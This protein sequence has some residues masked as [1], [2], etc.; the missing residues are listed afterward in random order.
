M[1][2]LSKKNLRTESVQFMNKSF[3]LTELDQMIHWK[4]KKKIIDKKSSKPH[5]ILVWQTDRN[6]C[7]VPKVS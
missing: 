3:L 4:D 1:K 2:N 5:D 7:Y 6:V